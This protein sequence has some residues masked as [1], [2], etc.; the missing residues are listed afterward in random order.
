MVPGFPKPIH[1][2]ADFRGRVIP[3]I[4]F[5][6]AMGLGPIPENHP[7]LVVIARFNMQLQPLMVYPVERIV[8]PRWPEIIP[9]PEATCR[10]EGNFLTA[11]T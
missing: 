8:N 3:V 4:E 6:L 5:S 2:I 1:G 11:V 9:T 7:T 10:G